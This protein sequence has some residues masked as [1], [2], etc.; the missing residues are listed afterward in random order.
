[1]KDQPSNVDASEFRVIAILA[2]GR[3]GTTLL[4]NEL[5]KPAEVTCL[6]SEGTFRWFEAN[7]ALLA[8]EDARALATAH[9]LLAQD[10]HPGGFSREDLKTQF[11]SAPAPSALTKRLLVKLPMFRFGAEGRG[12]FRHVHVIRLFR[13]PLAIVESMCRPLHWNEGHPFWAGPRAELLQLRT[14]DLC[15]FARAEGVGFSPHPPEEAVARP[16][17][18]ACATWL[19]DYIAVDEELR[20]RPGFS[21]SATEVRFEDFVGNRDRELQRLAAFMGVAAPDFP[22]HRTSYR[23]VEGEGGIASNQDT[24]ADGRGSR[25][26]VL[27]EAQRAEVCEVLA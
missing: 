2:P 11:A 8:G 15:A 26:P 9:P 18:V 20:T 6:S 12:R 22:P 7:H 23:A 27:T 16:Y 17:H 3:S 19:A 4:R 24:G 25:T 1:M 13:D 5:L 14:A 10:W 21:A